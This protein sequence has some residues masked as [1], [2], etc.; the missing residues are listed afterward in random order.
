MEWIIPLVLAIATGVV[1]VL[2]GLY[3]TTKPQDTTVEHP[4][5]HIEVSNGRSD[6]ERLNDLGLPH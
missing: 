2:R 5:P 1:V 6:Q 3:G 4:K